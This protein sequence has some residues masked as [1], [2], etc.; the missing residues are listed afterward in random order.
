MCLLF[1]V[2]ESVNKKKLQIFLSIEYFISDKEEPL[3]LLQTYIKS[4]DLGNIRD[5]FTLYANI[6]NIYT[7]CTLKYVESLYSMISD[8][9]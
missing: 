2:Q 5:T 8:L 3:Q 6:L 4:S 9:P 1:K 7:R